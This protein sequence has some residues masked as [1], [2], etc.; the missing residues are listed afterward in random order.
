[1]QAERN[2][3][4]GKAFEKEVAARLNGNRVGLFGGMDVDAGIFAIECKTRKT[5]VATSWMEQ[6]I[7]NCKANKLPIVIVHVTGK[8]HDDDLVIVRMRDFQSWYGK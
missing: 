8:R 6:S 3:K 4:R 2:R 1:M 7:R 5:F